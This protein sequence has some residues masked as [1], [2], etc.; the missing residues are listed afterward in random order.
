[1]VG[2]SHR[3]PSDPSHR[4]FKKPPHVYVFNLVTF[5]SVDDL[6]LSTEAERASV[7][8]ELYS[9]QRR[10]DMQD[11]RPPSNEEEPEQE[12]EEEEDEE[13]DIAQ[14]MAMRVLRSKIPTGPPAGELDLDRD[15]DADLAMRLTR[16]EAREEENVKGAQAHYMRLGMFKFLGRISQA[17]H[18]KHELTRNA[19]PPRVDVTDKTTVSTT[20]HVY[21]GSDKPYTSEEILQEYGKYTTSQLIR[22]ALAR[23]KEDGL[24]PERTAVDLDVIY[25]PTRTVADLRKG[26]E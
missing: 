20:L 13:V 11:Q 21:Y 15:F 19:I 25:N 24:A 17:G 6:L 14:A 9:A 23:S 5:G 7:L 12:E 10:S 1:V 3:A 4:W 18:A 16:D 8:V 26:F 2:R 22:D